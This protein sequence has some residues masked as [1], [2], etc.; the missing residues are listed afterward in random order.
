MSRRTLKRKQPPKNGHSFITIPDDSD[1]EAA[2]SAPVMHRHEIIQ[3][4][5]KGRASTRSTYFPLM[6]SPKKTA[7]GTFTLP[8]VENLDSL[9]SSQALPYSVANVNEGID[10]ID[11]ATSGN[12]DHADFDLEQV[13]FQGSD[14][15]V[16]G[17]EPQ[18]KRP[19]NDGVSLLLRWSECCS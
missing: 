1:E 9:F 8:P 10:I 2:I 15:H 3:G 6:S 12:F 17:S 14:S 18:K 5:L 4:T 16:P 7:T 19:R 11:Y 13:S